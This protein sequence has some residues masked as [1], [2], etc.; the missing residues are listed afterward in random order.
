[1]KSRISDTRLEREEAQRRDVEIINR[2]ADRL[3]AEA[4]DALG[5]QALCAQHPASHALPEKKTE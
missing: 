2:N 4:E 1:M 5:Y 3:N